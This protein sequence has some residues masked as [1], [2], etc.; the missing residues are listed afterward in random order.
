MLARLRPYAS[1]WSVVAGVFILDVLTKLWV[2]S[3]I[4][5]G[6]YYLD[7]PERAPLVIFSR[8][9]IVHVGNK[10]AAWGLGAQYDVRPF[11]VLL[12]FA[13]LALVWR[14]RKPLLRDCGGG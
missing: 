2:V 3:A 13:V 4:P 7:D 12:A 10:G 5:F 8:L 11:L 14:W 6:Y 1:F 9:W